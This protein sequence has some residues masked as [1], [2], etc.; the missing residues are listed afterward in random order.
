[1]ELTKDLEYMEVHKVLMYIREQSP[2]NKELDT[3]KI[4]T[5][6]AFNTF[7]G[8]NVTIKMYETESFNVSVD[9][10]QDTTLNAAPQQNSYLG[11]PTIGGK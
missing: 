4:S 2:Q 1:M 3:P 9:S 6:E 10:V 7:R 8:E 11:I 5:Q